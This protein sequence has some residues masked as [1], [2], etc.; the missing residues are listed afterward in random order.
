MRKPLGSKPLGS[1]PLV[2]KTFV[3]GEIMQNQI[4]TKK[5]DTAKLM[6]QQI[7]EAVTTL[8]KQ[9]K[10]SEVSA[11]EIKANSAVGFNV[12]VR[13]GEVETLEYNRDKAISIT[14]YHGQ[15]KGTASTTD[16]TIIA[17][18]QCLEK[19][20]SIAQRTQPDPYAGLADA[21][22]MAKDYPDLDLYHPWD[23][24]PTQAIKLAQQCEAK[25]MAVDP[26]LKNSEGV[27]VAT[28]QHFHIYANSHDFLGQFNSTMHSI[29]CV[30]IAEQDGAKERDYSY[31][32][33][34]DYRDLLSIEHLAMEAAERTVKRLGAKK[35]STRQVPVIFLADVAKGLLRHFLEAISGSSLYRQA[36][37][38]LN[39]LG[40]PIFPSFINIRQQP[41]QPKMIGSAPF[42]QEGVKTWDQDLIANG[43]LKNYI[44]SS[45]SA[46]KLSMQTT[47][48]AGGAHNV[49]VQSGENN[50]QQLLRK[51]DTGLLITELLGHGVN[52][53]TG[54]YS[55]GAAGYWVEKGE[56]AYPVHEI[57]IAGNL[58]DMLKNI[59]AI[60]NDVDFRGNIK[61]GSI[62]IESMMIAGE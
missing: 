30:L 12:N 4:I 2:S 16:T 61:T 15:C 40:K 37:F 53:V 11:Y 59:V 3:I 56:V 13:L 27:S 31:T 48:N 24:E 33:A 36:S 49:I 60:G 19:A 18:K 26:R 28:S 7:M 32:V 5:D 46:R 23:I 45:Y 22:M 42:D 34:R 44:L 47:G 38:L 10:Q 51:M 62:L 29:D 21:N 43:V 25:A 9:V 20:T 55:R 14:V 17:L 57:T 50:L 54:D 39:C 6:Q 52:I 8:I 35:L 1:K 58:H 41:H